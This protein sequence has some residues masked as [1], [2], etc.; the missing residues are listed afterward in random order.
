MPTSIGFKAVL[1][2]LI[3]LKSIESRRLIISLVVGLVNVGM[4]P[5]VI[6]VFDDASSL[7]G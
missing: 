5:V 7:I 3:G 6:V 1:A 2:V 4:S